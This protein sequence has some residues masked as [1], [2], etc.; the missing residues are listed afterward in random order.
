MT[1]HI[2]FSLDAITV[3]NLCEKHSKRDFIR[4]DVQMIIVK[5]FHNAW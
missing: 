5:F 3:L 1:T 4:D 2:F